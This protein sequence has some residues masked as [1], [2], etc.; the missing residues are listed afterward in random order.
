MRRTMKGTAEIVVSTRA[1]TPTSETRP[2]RL[3]ESS[4]TSRVTVGLAVSDEE[5]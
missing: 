5:K 3:N 2:I 1:Q 4:R